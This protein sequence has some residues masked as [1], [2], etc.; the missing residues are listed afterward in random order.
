[1]VGGRQGTTS[2]FPGVAALTRSYRRRAVNHRISAPFTTWAR[3][4]LGVHRRGV[5]RR[6]ITPKRSSDVRERCASDVRKSRKHRDRAGLRLFSVKKAGPDTT[7][8][9]RVQRL[10]DTVDDFQLDCKSDRT[11]RGFILLVR[12]EVR[13]IEGS[14]LVSLS[15][16]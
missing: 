4:R 11:S 14:Y 10:A 3:K 15:C 6:K 5:E 1:L 8:G 9:P 2:V 7:P 16:R 13:A 12:G